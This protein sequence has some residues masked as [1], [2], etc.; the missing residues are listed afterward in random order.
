MNYPFT[1]SSA[2]STFSVAAL[3]QEVLP[4]IFLLLDALLASL[5][6]C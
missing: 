4:V 3:Y 2:K 5:F 6:T 1:I